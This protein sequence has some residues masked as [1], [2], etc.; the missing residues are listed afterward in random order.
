MIGKNPSAEAGEPAFP[1]VYE[2]RS[3]PP[4]L[5]VTGD[6]DKA[7][8]R[9]GRSGNDMGAE[10]TGCDGGINERIREEGFSAGLSPPIFSKTEVTRE[11]D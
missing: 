9:V 2:S 11:L 3:A 4:T 8:R 1:S 7:Q 10:P 6:L 5:E